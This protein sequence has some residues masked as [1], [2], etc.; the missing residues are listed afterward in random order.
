MANEFEMDQIL[1]PPRAVSLATQ[2]LAVV[3]A[4]FFVETLFICAVV[5]LAGFSYFNPVLRGE[6]AVVDSSHIEGWVHNPLAA[7]ERLVVQLWVDDRFVATTRAESRRDNLVAAGPVKDAYHG[8]SFTLADKQFSRGRHRAQVYV[9][10]ETARGARTL[11]PISKT[12]R[13]FQIT[14]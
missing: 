10:H 8:F 7:D 2:L 5:T 14:N 9:V 1:E 6:M 4:K 12:K 11:L 13:F 3:I